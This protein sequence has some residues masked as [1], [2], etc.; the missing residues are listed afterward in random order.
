MLILILMRVT[1]CD[2]ELADP[3]LSLLN[4][5][6]NILMAQLYCKNAVAVLNSFKS[7]NSYDLDMWVQFQSA[8]IQM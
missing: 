7:L 2:A 4:S 1:Q 5:D 8:C 3:R 6:T